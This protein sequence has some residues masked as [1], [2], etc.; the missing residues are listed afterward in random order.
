MGRRSLGE[1]RDEA[2][3]RALIARAQQNWTNAITATDKAVARGKTGGGT[4]AAERHWMS[5]YRRLGG[6]LPVTKA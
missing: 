3:R 2:E 4:M 1:P 5:E 6:K